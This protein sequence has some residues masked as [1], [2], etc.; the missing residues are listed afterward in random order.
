VRSLAA[1]PAATG[2]P[3]LCLDGGILARV[4]DMVLVRG[5]NVYPGAVEQII[6]ECGGV[7]EYQVRLFDRR[8]MSEIEISIE[9]AGDD[10]R[11][12]ERVE[13]ML[14][15]RL[16]LRIPVNRVAAGSLPRFEMKA[17][18]WVRVDAKPPN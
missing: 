14:Q 7:I 5:V 15:Q 4:D 12:R 18:R 6:H 8:A 17:R 13:T 3:E 9:A 2:T 1:N 10:D 16:A 11:V